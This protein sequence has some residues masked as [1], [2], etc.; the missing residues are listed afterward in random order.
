MPLYKHLEQFSEDK[1]VTYDKAKTFSQG[2]AFQASAYAA[3]NVI[4]GDNPNNSLLHGP[5]GV[6]LA[7]CQPQSEME[8]KCKQFLP[9]RVIQIEKWLIEAGCA[10]S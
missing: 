3:V 2:I 4:S 7:T 10:T 8:E 6:P 5:P 1:I 9:T